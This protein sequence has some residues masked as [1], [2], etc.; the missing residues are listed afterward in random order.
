MGWIALWYA[1]NI[2]DSDFVWIKLE[3]PDIGP[4]PLLDWVHD[5]I[6]ELI[7]NPLKQLTRRIEQ[8]RRKHG[9]RAQH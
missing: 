9:R 6:Q 1:R 8:K 5:H 3:D 4:M 7:D 2:T